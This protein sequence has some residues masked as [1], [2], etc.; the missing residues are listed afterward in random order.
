MIS[1][2]KWAGLG[3]S[4]AADFGELGKRNAEHV[5]LYTA[6]EEHDDADIRCA[7][8]VPLPSID[9][10]GVGSSELFAADDTAWPL[11]PVIRCPFGG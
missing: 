5:H 10:I 2:V 9:A 11:W 3:V 7:R 8:V 4:A 1:S 6:G